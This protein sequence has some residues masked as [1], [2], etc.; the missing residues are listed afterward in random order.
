[1][2]K[3]KVKALVFQARESLMT[4]RSARDTDCQEIQEQ[5]ATLRGAALR[6]VS[7]R[8]HVAVCPACAAFRAE[9]RRQRAGLA[10]VLPVVPGVL[11]KKSVLAAALGGGG[12]GGAALV[13][14]G[15]AGGVAGGGLAAKVLVAVAIAGG[16]GGG[17]VIAVQQLEH[18]HARPKTVTPAPRTTGPAPAVRTGSTPAQ[19]TAHVL[20]QNKAAKRRSSH[21][22]AGRAQGAHP[23]RGHAHGQTKA[24]SKRAKQHPVK[25]DGPPRRSHAKAQ[26]NAKAHSTPATKPS[27]GRKHARQP[28]PRTKPVPEKGRSQGKPP[29]R[30]VPGPPAPA[31][32]KHAAKTHGG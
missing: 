14:G 17:G 13:A 23:G 27:P 8:R 1:V 21:R 2:R 30:T 26:P 19:P 20:A 6:R 29:A 32:Q 3:D 24:N 7:L 22:S 25:R 9:V 10:L 28:Q 18:H 31:L 5:L 4:S 12:A 11:L 16:A 15:T